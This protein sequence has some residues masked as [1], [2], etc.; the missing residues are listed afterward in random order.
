MAKGKQ[1]ES[2]QLKQVVELYN[3]LSATEQAIF[4]TKEFN[5]ML[6]GL[7]SEAKKAL[8]AKREELLA[9]I[10]KKQAVNAKKLQAAK[11]LAAKME[12][13][14]DLPDDV[15]KAVLEERKKA[16]GKNA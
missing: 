1:P 8:K 11:E 12:A 3:Q 2:D 5:G 9:D 16:K 13:L 15:L 4:R 10:A 7:E 14:K 6:S